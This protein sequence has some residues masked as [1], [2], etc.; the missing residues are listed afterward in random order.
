[1]GILADCLSLTNL[2]KAVMLTSAWSGGND[3]ELLVVRCWSTMYLLCKCRFED[4]R[5]RFECIYSE[6]QS[7]DGRRLVVAMPKGD[8]LKK[9]LRGGG[10]EGGCDKK[11][12]VVQLG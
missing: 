9:S 1:M 5:N 7:D 3:T 8:V 4:E 10:R 2:S 6:L 11:M 12:G